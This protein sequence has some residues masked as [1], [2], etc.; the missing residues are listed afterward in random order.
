MEGLAGALVV[1]KDS[2][3]LFSWESGFTLSCIPSLALVHWPLFSDILP[4]EPSLLH[5]PSPPSPKRLQHKRRALPGIWHQPASLGFQS[6]PGDFEAMPGSEGAMRAL[7]EA[8]HK[9]KTTCHSLCSCHQTLRFHHIHLYVGSICA[10]APKHR[11]RLSHRELGEACREGRTW[12]LGP[13]LPEAQPATHCS[14]AQPDWP[15]EGPGTGC[16][17]LPTVGAARL[18]K[19]GHN[20]TL[21]PLVD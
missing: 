10:Y 8:C 12:Q 7:S 17:L 6:P 11:E 1:R 15:G 21:S 19:E 3:G 4:Q 5:P 9:S 16:C 14:Q 18:G 20:G 13:S 2:A